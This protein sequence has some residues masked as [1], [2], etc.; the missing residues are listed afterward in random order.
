[1]LP[2]QRVDRNV[3]RW[4]MSARLHLGTFP[5]PV[6]MRPITGQP[7]GEPTV[8]ESS[9]ARLLGQ[10]DPS[11]SMDAS[12]RPPGS[13]YRDQE[14]YRAERD[15]VFKNQWLLAARED[16][17]RASGDYASCQVASEPYV[18]V[19]DETDSL[20]AYYNVCRHQAAAVVVGA[21][22]APALVCPFHGWTYGLDGCLQSAPD[23]DDDI[24]DGNCDQ[25][26]FG[27][28]PMQVGEIGPLIFI[29]MAEASRSIDRD[30]ADFQSHLNSLDISSLT[31]VTRENYTLGC[32][33]KAW[34]DQYLGSGQPNGRWT[35]PNLMIGQSGPLFETWRVTPRAPEECELIV[36]YY[37]TAQGDDLDTALDESRAAI[38]DHNAL[39]RSAQK[40]ATRRDAT[41]SAGR[42][43]GYSRSDTAK[44][45]FHVRL[46]TDFRRQLPPPP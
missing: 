18:I 45:D 20:R 41:E 38:K 33:W 30:L 16:Q 39:A 1:M 36:D 3:E 10:F 8:T 21:G 22:N 15:T 44:F 46:A 4:S 5:D 35:Y 19:R 37:D 31:F 7:E 25:S 9:P 12:T 32:N 40:D 28:L 26:Q 29:C 6:T 34:I 27:L 43:M 42:Q 23:I 11:L 24:N 17:L 14:I 2:H 13:W